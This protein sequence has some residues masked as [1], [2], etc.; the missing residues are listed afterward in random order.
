MFRIPLVFDFAMAYSLI[1][2]TPCRELKIVFQIAIFRWLLTPRPSPLIF[3]HF[4]ETTYRGFKDFASNSFF[5]EISRLE[6]A[7]SLQKI[8]CG[9]TKAVLR[10]VA[11]SRGDAITHVVRRIY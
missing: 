1:L 3:G 10:K 7:D 4:T 8:D 9:G 11:V 5:F 2:D 6:V